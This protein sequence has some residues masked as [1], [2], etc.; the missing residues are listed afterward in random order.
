M[1]RGQ[2]FPPEGCNSRQLI[3][4]FFL[5]APP[6]AVLESSAGLA[7]SAGLLLSVFCEFG[8]SPSGLCASVLADSAFAGASLAKV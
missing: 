4:P 6:P 1:M 5:V 2:M 7:S 3:P 8:L